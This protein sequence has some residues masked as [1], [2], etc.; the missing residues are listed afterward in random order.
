MKPNRATIIV[1]VMIIFISLGFKNPGEVN[2]NKR[3]HLFMIERNR[4]RD[5]IQYDVNIDE[6][7]NLNLADPIIAYWVRQSI[8]HQR[9]PLTTIQK[10]LSYG[11][12]VT[13]RQPDS[14]HICSFRFVSVP[15]RIFNL[16]RYGDTFSVLIISGGREIIVEKIYV[17]IIGGSFRLPG[18]AKVELHGTEAAT[19]NRVMEIITPLS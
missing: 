4:D 15:D 17:E 5:I 8:N 16:V 19:G 12:R 6:A 11:I 14:Q 10:R 2:A 7:G 9:E 13:D 18:V 1:S 3:N